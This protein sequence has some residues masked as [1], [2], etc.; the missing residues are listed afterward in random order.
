MSAWA[1]D[2]VPRLRPWEAALGAQP[3]SP[4]K[5]SLDA[6]YGKMFPCGPGPR[7]GARRVAGAVASPACAAARLQAA[8][9]LV[10]LD[11]A[12]ACLQVGGTGDVRGR[13]RVC[14]RSSR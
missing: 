12:V 1:G 8:G 10:L 3:D 2:L 5:A 6:Q 13:W 7:P 11:A 9:V 14:S 4:E